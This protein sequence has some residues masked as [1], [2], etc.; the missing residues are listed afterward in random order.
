MVYPGESRME[1][2][3]GPS[4]TPAVQVDDYNYPFSLLFIFTQFFLLRQRQD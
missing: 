3:L 2:S 1:G 4:M